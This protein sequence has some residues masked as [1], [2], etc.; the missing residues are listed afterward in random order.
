M[1]RSVAGSNDGVWIVGGGRMMPV[2]MDVLDASLST[3]VGSLSSNG[4]DKEER[5][6]YARRLESKESQPELPALTKLATDLRYVHGRSV[7]CSAF[8][9][10]FLAS[11]RISIRFLHC[12]ANIYRE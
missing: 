11:M 5:D 7:K 8:N 2:G 1:V 10:C 6:S 12:V 9:K 4:G 3:Y